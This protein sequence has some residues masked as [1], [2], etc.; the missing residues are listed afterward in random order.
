MT[1]ICA[2]PR[3]AIYRWTSGIGSSHRTGGHFTFASPHLFGTL[4]VERG[5]F[6][7]SPI[8]LVA[9]IGMAQA[10]DWARGLVVVTIAVLLVHTYVLASWYVWDLGVGFGHRGYVDV[11]PFLAI[12]VGLLRAAGREPR[13][14]RPIAVLAMLL[15]V[16]SAVQM[17]H[18]LARRDSRRVHDLGAVSGAASSLLMTRRARVTSR[19]SSSAWC[20][21][22][23]TSGSALDWRGHV[24]TATVAGGHRSPARPLDDGARE[25]FRAERG[26]P[27]DATVPMRRA[28][29]RST[30]DD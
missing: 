5:V 9:P 6:F 2:M 21:R 7:W 29:F 18:D 20:R 19:S 23:G 15:V 30:G 25:F 16:L 1:L 28:A 14:R 26:D 12:F 10:R 4:F 17:L 11:L 3:L 27:D 13:L 24:R 8:L 22:S